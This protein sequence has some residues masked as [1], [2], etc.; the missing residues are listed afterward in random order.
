MT[1]T[2]PPIEQILVNLTGKTLSEG[3]LY[4][5]GTLKILDYSLKGFKKVKQWVIDKKNEHKLGF[6]P[7]KKEAEILNLLEE[8][9]DYELVE[10][11]IPKYRYIDI[12]RTGLLV[13]QYMDDDSALNKGKSQLIK[14]QIK[15]KSNGEYLLSII[16]L[17]TTPYFIVV[18]NDLIRLKQQGYKETQLMDEF[19]ESIISWKDS[20]LPVKGTFSITKI[21]NFCIKKIELEKKKIFLIGIKSAAK[22]VKQAIEELQQ[23]KFFEK[24]GYEERIIQQ[25]EGV[26]PRIEVTIR[27]IKAFDEFI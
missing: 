11:L 26:E 21:K 1:P 9:P 19:D 3:L 20:Y 15:N 2:I 7:D 16:H 24:N 6:V 8:D 12:I 18:I 5:A 13:K 23:K 22:N 25:K 27:R 10:K 17:V 14:N 4:I